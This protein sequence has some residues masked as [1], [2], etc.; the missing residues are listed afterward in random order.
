VARKGFIQIP[1]IAFDLV[2]NQPEAFAVLDIYKL[3]DKARHEPLKASDRYLS[4]RWSMTNRQTRKVF[5]KMVEAGLIKILDDGDRTNPRTIQVVKGAEHY[6]EHQAEHQAEQAK[7]DN[8]LHLPFNMEH[9]PEHQAEHQPERITKV[10]IKTNSIPPKSPRKRGPTDADVMQLWENLLTMRAKAKSNAR[11]LT[12]TKSRQ[13]QLKGRMREYSTEQI[14]QAWRWWL[15]CPNDDAVLLRTS[16]DIDTFMRP[17]KFDRYQAASE[18]WMSHVQL[19]QPDS[20]APIEEWVAYYE[21][22]SRQNVIQP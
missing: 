10:S 19:E 7:R 11:S 4:K 22:E 21:Q 2:S 12:L 6:A 20:N 17:S 5:N 16:W 14:E 15:E 1:R 18:K 8:A 3:A 13:R 9:Q